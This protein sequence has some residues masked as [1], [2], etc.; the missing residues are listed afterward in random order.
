MTNSTDKDYNKGRADQQMF[1]DMF[2]QR[3]KYKL[4]EY[5]SKYA[6]IDFI[7][8]DGKSVVGFAEYKHRKISKDQYDHIVIDHNKMKKLRE[9]KDGSNKPAYLILTYLDGTYVYELTGQIFDIEYGGRTKKTR[10]KYDI[11]VVEKIPSNK[12]KHIDIIFKDA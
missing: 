7:L 6:P 1:M 3:Y 9:H 5:P 4:V 10:N 12:F 11:K 2:N 8:L